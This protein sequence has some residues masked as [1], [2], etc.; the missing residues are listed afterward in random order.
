VRPVGVAGHAVWGVEIDVDGP[1]D[2]DGLAL[3]VAAALGVAVVLADADGLGVTPLFGIALPLRVLLGE[4]ELLGVPLGVLLGAGGLAAG[5]GSCLTSAADAV[6]AREG[7]R[8]MAR[9]TA[10]NPET[11]PLIVAR[12]I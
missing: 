5:Q 8:Q 3:G 1:D 4:A 11:I 6:G 7:I 2:A 12:S 10:R 9:L